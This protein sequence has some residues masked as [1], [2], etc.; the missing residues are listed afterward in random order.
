MKQFYSRLLLLAIKKTFL[1]LIVFIGASYVSSGQ[2]YYATLNGPNEFPT[3]TSPGVG[4]GVI[5][6]DGNLM[7]V[8]ATF[9]G[10]V[11]QTAAGLPAVRQLHTFMLLPPSPYH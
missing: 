9:S 3:N 1:L 7:R 8:Q 11:T 10:L 2:V 4:K 5:T 6:I